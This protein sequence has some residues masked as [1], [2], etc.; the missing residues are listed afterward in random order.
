MTDNT[1]MTAAVALR[2]SFESNVTERHAYETSKSA[3]SA[4]AK[5]LRYFKATLRDDVLTHNI[6][7]E[8]FARVADACSLES[9]DFINSSVRETNRFNIYAVEKAA[10]MMRSIAS[11]TCQL[12]KYSVALL[13]TLYKNKSR[14]DFYLS[15]KD[16]YSLMCR[17]VESSLAQDERVSNV[18][19]TANTATTQVSSS[20]RALAAL[21]VLRFDDELKRVSD[22]DFDH[23]L[24]AIV[25]KY[26]R[27]DK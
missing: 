20:L 8:V 25:A 15:R 11:N 27:L 1:M 18:R 10:K 17:D 3:H 7:D 2:A 26:K 23:A 12:D 19:V 22:I 13:A 4:A 14:D 6:S 24:F 5:L 21:N 16:A 9:F